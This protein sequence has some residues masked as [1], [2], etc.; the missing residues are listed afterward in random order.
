MTA[1]DGGRIAHGIT[2][3]THPVDV[4]YILAIVVEE[5][6]E[7]THLLQHGQR[8]QPEGRIDK[9]DG[10]ERRLS[11]D[12]RYG[13]S[14]QASIGSKARL[15]PIARAGQMDGRQYAV[16]RIAVGQLQQRL[17]RPLTDPRILVEQEDGLASLLH[18]VGNAQIVGS[19]E[20]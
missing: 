14:V 2:V 9:G 20:T 1:R 11:I 12:L 17:Q 3:E 8:N 18:G 13:L 6:A 7:A 4:V 19:S 16:L 15:Q 10:V 5:R